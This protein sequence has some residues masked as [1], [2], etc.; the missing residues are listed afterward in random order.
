MRLVP[1]ESLHVTLVFVGSC[2]ED[3]I[4]AIGD[5]VMGEARPL[6]PLAVSTAAWLPARRPGVLVADLIEDG[7]R[8]ADLQDDLAAALA[9]WHEPE[10]RAFRPHVTVARVRR[11][12]SLARR[13]VPDPPRLIFDPVALLLHRSFPGPGG[14]RYEAAARVSL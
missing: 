7:S 2:P 10:Q 3:E 13:D 4:G 5:V 12:Q 1:T 14:S 11:G 8:L 6:D 9:P